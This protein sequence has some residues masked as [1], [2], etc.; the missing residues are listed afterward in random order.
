LHLL[1]ATGTI[2]YILMGLVLTGMQPYSQIDINAP[3]SVAF[4]AVSQPVNGQQQ[5]WG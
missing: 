1:P 3:F 5:H 4:K 2:L